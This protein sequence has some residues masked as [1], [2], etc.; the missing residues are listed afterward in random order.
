[1]IE[2]YKFRLYPNEE[3]KVLLNKHFGCVRFVYNWAL[4]YSQQQYKVNKKFLG[5]QSIAVSNEFRNLKN[6]KYWLR[7]VNSQSIC[8]SIAHLGKAFDRFF[9][10]QGGFPKLKSKNDNN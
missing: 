7:E 3:Q 4:I 8:N 9:K 6:E 1:M 5:W 2:T 10:H